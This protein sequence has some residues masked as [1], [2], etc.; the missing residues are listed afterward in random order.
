MHARLSH[1]W[2]ALRKDNFVESFNTTANREPQCVAV[3]AHV[4][5]DKQCMGGTTAHKNRSLKT[6]LKKIRHKSTP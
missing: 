5:S 4:K 2:W 6:H 3:P 1:V